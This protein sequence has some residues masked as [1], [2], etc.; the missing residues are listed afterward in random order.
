MGSG[1]GN[2]SHWISL[3]KAGRIT[4][5]FYGKLRKPQYMKYLEG[6]TKKLP[7]K[8]RGVKLKY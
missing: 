3:A 4:C 6:V 5:E 1:K 2:H 8:A 7:V